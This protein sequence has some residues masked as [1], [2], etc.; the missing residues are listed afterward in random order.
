[1]SCQSQ[2]PLEAL[3]LEGSAMDH[4]KKWPFHYRI[5]SGSEQGVRKTL[6][7]ITIDFIE[8][9]ITESWMVSEKFKQKQKQYLE[10]KKRHAMAVKEYTKN[11]KETAQNNAAKEKERQAAQKRLD[12]ILQAQL[13]EYKKKLVQQQIH[14][15]RPAMNLPGASV[16]AARSVQHTDR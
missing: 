10:K 15:G 4:E 5:R 6:A 12:K 3:S 7:R 9:D 1:M 16:G 2:P 13:K 11:M 14:K 8:M